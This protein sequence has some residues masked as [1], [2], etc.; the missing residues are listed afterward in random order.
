MKP[1]MV[2][3]TEYIV[4][5]SGHRQ[6]SE[7]FALKSKKSLIKSNK[8]TWI[9]GPWKFEASR[10][11]PGTF[12][13]SLWFWLKAAAITNHYLTWHDCLIVDVGGYTILTFKT[14]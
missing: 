13:D 12:E 11:P 2:R 4:R 14:R 5:S 1:F 8:E 7:R 3:I 6:L 10:E 9:P